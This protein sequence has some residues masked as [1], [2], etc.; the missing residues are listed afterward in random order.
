MVDV[1]PI[2]VVRD[3][4]LALPR[5]ELT[6]IDREPIDLDRANAQHRA[7]RDA[8][9]AAGLRVVALPAT[10]ELPD[11]CFVEDLLLDLGDV[12][13]LTSPGADSRQPEREAMRAAFEAGAPLAGCGPLVEM[14]DGLR[15]DGGDVLAIRDLVYVGLSTRTDRDAVEWL[16]QQTA[17]KVLGVPLEGALHL[18]TAVSALSE[19]VLV[20]TPGAVEERWFP[21]FDLIRTPAGE[22]PAAN[23]LRLPPRLEVV[24]ANNRDERALMDARCTRSIACARRWGIDV[25]PVDISEFAKAEAGLTCLSVIL[26]G[27]AS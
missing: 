12:R 14:P 16:A 23:A 11:S 6:W 2:A 20:L 8:L 21:W 25:T 4:P 24:D 15:L 9:D 27:G 22:E 5:C 13:I 18:K 7:Y 19:N 26:E 10:H 17:R 3:V 1:R